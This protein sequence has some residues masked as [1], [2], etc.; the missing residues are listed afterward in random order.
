MQV[1]L[2]T[3]GDELL[4]GKTL[5]TNATYIAE[6]LG[7]IG[8]T[9]VRMTTIG[10]TLENIEKALRAAMRSV[11]AVV[12]TGGLGP[13]PDDVTRQAAAQTFG[14]KMIFREDIYRDIEM[15]W[16]RR[17]RPVPESAKILA[18]VPEGTEVIKNAV[19][20]AAG[21]KIKHENTTFFFLPGV[22]D[23]MRSMMDDCVLPF[24][25]EKAAGRALRHRLLKTAGITESAIHEK[26]KGVEE[27]IQGVK[28]AY[29]PQQYEVHL[30]LTAIGKSVKVAENH[31]IQVEKV[32]RERLGYY[33][34]GIND[35][36]LE[37][38]IS[39]L[40][41]EKGMSISVA[42]SCTGGLISG[43]LTDIPGS[44]NFL[45]R[46]VV[47]YSG[48]AKNEMLS[49]S[50]DMLEKYGTV[51][52]ETTKTMA[53]NMRTLGRTD[54]GLA[55]TGIMGPT[56]GTE[57][58]PVGTAYVGLAHPGGSHLKEFHFLGDRRT[59]K[60]FAAQAALNEV[61]LFLQKNIE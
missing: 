55:V 59:N 50:I 1:E 8:A 13:T 52:P 49:I 37:E 45:K 57:E 18:L 38:V 27:R 4:Y 2:I 35:E 5:D 3:I 40:L 16:K 23:E 33:I 20:A 51:S 39:G 22:P 24:L 31:L 9:V 6:K 61:R 12:V 7:E 19:G 58:I 44:S 54:I 60:Q 46:G 43:R 30:R 36:C 47:A 53:E 42:E 41:L 34:Y 25:T 48:Q 32:V 10:D 14:L 56:G 21:L 15:R 29:L 28:I 11:D 17:G 26:L